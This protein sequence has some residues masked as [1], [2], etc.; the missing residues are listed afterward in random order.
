[1]SAGNHQHPSLVVKTGNARKATMSRDTAEKRTGK[2]GRQRKLPEKNAQSS[3]LTLTMGVPR[4]IAALASVSALPIP[5][6]DV[7]TGSMTIC[8]ET[9]C[10]RSR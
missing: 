4:G 6:A 2:D 3:N 7:L 10:Q 5:F 8:G 9:R 1:M